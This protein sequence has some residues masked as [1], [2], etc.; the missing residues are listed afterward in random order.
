M[1]FKSLLPLILLLPA[2][3]SAATVCGLVGTSNPDT[4]NQYMGNFFYNGPSNFALCAAWCKNDATRCRSFRWSYYG[5]ANSQYCEF[6]EVA[7]DGLVTADDTQ[8]FWYYDV[9]CG[10]PDFIAPATVTTTAGDGAGNPAQTVTTTTTTTVGDAPGA[11]TITQTTTTTEEAAPVTRT[12]TQLVTQTQ[13]QTQTETQLS[14]TT[15][16]R[17]TVTAQRRITGYVTRLSTRTVFRTVTS[18]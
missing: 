8:P 1:S 10:F 11:I 2:T 18:R 16:A 14:T 3:I 4:L 7:L 6:F 13:T 15:V 5:D 17:R 12:Q 9:A